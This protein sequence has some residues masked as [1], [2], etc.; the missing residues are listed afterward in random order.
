MSITIGSGANRQLWLWIFVVASFITNIVSAD[1]N[2]GITI[3]DVSTRI[4]INVVDDGVEVTVDLAEK[5]V[6]KLQAETSGSDKTGLV[7]AFVKKAIHIKADSELT[8]EL[9][10][11]VAEGSRIVFFRFSKQPEQ[12][13]IIPDFKAIEKAGEKYLITV[14]HQGLP[15][16]DHGVLTSKET[17]IL[18]WQDPWYSH[19]KNPKLKRGHSDPVMAFL[20]I[21]PRQVKSEIVVRVKEMAGWMDLGLRD[22]VMIYPDEFPVVK[23]K[24]G[25]FLLTQNHLSAD[26]KKLTPVLGRVDYIQMGAADIQA[27]KPQK[28]QNQAA[29]LIGVSIIHQIKAIPEKLQ[30]HWQLFNDQIQRVAIRAYDPAGLFDSYV[31]PK[32]P[33]FEWD[34]MLSDIDLPMPEAK[35]QSMPVPVEQAGQSLKYLWLVIVVGL[36]ILGVFGYRSSGQRFHKV[37][38]PVILFVGFM[39]G[40]LSLNYGWSVFG[41]G[42]RLDEQRAKTVLKQLLWNVYQ[43]FEAPQEDAAYDQLA[44]SVSG[45]L[46]EMLYLQNRQSFLVADGAISDVKRIEIQSLNDISPLFGDGNLIDCEW[47]VIG[48]V[49]HWGHQHR[50]ENKYHARIKVLPMGGYWKIVAIEPIGQQRVDG[51]GA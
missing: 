17:L 20:Y 23:K 30:W 26:S 10:S 45:D 44:Y 41:A 42:S 35:P 21:E 37:I 28:A 3:E 47:L 1:W 19:F 33:V 24:I 9:K 5:A 16:I 29:T 6:A 34:N 22:K 18:D 51:E 43:A 31:T 12:L 40:Y 32:Y 36:L 13:E 14:A 39:M 4:A 11:D 48:E 2:S 27:Y 49:I 7:D 50:R 15:V 8:S 38:L 25:Q 46:Q